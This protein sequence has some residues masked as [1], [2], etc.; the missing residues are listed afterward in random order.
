MIEVLRAHPALAGQ[1]EA[2]LAVVRAGGEAPGRI[3]AA[4]ESLVKP[5]RALGL[6]VLGRVGPAETDGTILPQV[7]FTPGSGDRR[8]RRKVVW[9]ENP[10]VRG[11]SRRP[12]P[13]LLRRELRRPQRGRRPRGTHRPASRLGQPERDSRRGPTGPSGSPAWPNSASAPEAISTSI[14]STSS[15]TPPPPPCAPRTATW[16]IAAINS[17]TRARSRATCRSAPG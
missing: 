15:N 3:D 17:T 14:Y 10:A 2:V 6:E 8:K 4:E 5:L 1:V 11:P 13:D 9:P 16:I 7:E 12:N